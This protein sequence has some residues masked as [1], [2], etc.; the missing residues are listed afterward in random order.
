MNCA[1]LP[2]NLIEAELFGHE[3]GSFTG[4]AKTRHG[5]FE[6][7]DGGTLVPRRARAPCRCRRRTGC[8]ARSNMARSPGSARRSR[9]RST[10]GSSPRPTRIS[11][12]RSTRASSAPTCSTGCRSRSSP[13]RRCGR[14]RATSR[15]SPSIS[16]G[17]WRSSSTGRTGRASRRARMAE[18][19]AYPWP[20][21][22]RELRNVV[23]RAVYRHEDPERPVDEI[24]FD[25]F[26]SPW[27]PSAAR[28][29]RR[30]CAG[31]ALRTSRRRRRSCAPVP[32]ARRQPSS[33][34]FRAAVADY[35]RAAARGRAC[36]ATAST[37]ARPRPRSTSATTSSAMR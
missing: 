7:A 14:A 5:R 8:C 28:P 23:E 20:G 15:C 29:H 32:A 2:E 37:S 30:R 6:E 35:E 9:S 18:L 25:P 33:S 22:V 27:A 10:C 31:D 16:G 17:A 12:R 11:R 4:A 19:E 3:A 34:D 36:A 13:C 21:N 26:H 1:A 24:N